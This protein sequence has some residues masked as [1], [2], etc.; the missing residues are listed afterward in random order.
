M[1]ISSTLRI[2]HLSTL[3]HTSFILMANRWLEEK[4]DLNIEWNMFGG[5]PAI[6]DAFSRGA[7]DI[8]YVGLPPVMIGIDRGVSI[9]CV[10]GGH[11]EGTVMI[12]VPGSKSLQETDGSILAVLEQ[13]NDSTIGCPPSGSIHDV[14][15]RDLIRQYGLDGSI[16]V[17]NFSWA[18][19]IPENVAEVPEAEGI[20]QLLD[21]NENVIYIKGAMNMRQEMEEQLETNA[22]ARYFMY[23]R[24]EMFTKKESELLQ[25]YI[26]EY[27][28]MPEGNRE[29]D[30]LF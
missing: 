6:V 28:E 13:F 11:I 3:Y 7:V 18:D 26:A 14:I 23:E 12:A 30:D 29:L 5:G 24:D 19:F 22:N 27:G 10:G 20:Y 25:Q 1:N 21:E 2:G 4:L 15:I 9:V 17:K 16:D 8:G